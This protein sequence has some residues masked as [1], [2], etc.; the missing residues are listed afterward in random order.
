V[1]GPQPAVLVV[2]ENRGL[3]EH[4]RDVTRRFANAGFVALGIDLLSRQGGTAAFADDTA[5]ATAYGRTQ[6]TERHEDMVAAVDYLRKQPNV[7]AGKIGAIGFCAGGGNVLYSIYN[8][9]NLQAAVTFYGTPPTTL[10][11]DRVSTP[12]L[13]IYSEND[14]AQ[15]ARIS[16]LAD[17]LVNARVTFGVHLYKGT[18]HAFFNDT[19]PA[20][21]REAAVDAWARTIEFFDAQLRGPRTA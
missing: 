20:Y 18:N 11:P 17:S 16:A 13:A 6:Q 12:L 4:I 9:L 5:R 7:V 14:R 8:G 2:H 1:N 15:A 3:T 19:G 10:P 21:N